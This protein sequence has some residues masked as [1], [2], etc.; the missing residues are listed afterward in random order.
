MGIWLESFEVA[1]AES[2]YGSMPPT[3]LARAVGVIPVTARNRT[4]G[5]RMRPAS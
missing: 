4:A 2:F 1:R 5:T 3:G